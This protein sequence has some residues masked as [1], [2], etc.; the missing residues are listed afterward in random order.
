[1]R[2]PLQSLSIVWV[3]KTNVRRFGVSYSFDLGK[4]KEYLVCLTTS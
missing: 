3:V 2:V 1:M 4:G